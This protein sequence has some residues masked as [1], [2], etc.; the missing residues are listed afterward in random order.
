MKLTFLGATRTVTGSKY[1]IDVSGRKILIDCGLFQG[2]KAL[3]LRNWDSFPIDPNSIDCVLLTHAHI[4]HSGYIPLLVK[5]GFSGPILCTKAT[6]DLCE[7]LLPDSGHIQEEDAKRA[8]KYGYSK[9][10]PAK[11]LYTE[12]EARHALKR[13]QTV[14]FGAAYPLSEEISITFSHASHILG[15]SSIRLSYKG[16]SVLFSGDIGRLNDPL[17]NPPDKISEAEYVILESTYGDRLHEKSDPLV[18]IADIVQTTA[19]KGGSVLIPAFAVGRAQT[20]LYYLYQL[21]KSRAISPD[22][23]IFVD[24]PMATNATHLICK[25]TEELRIPVSE[26]RQICDRATYIQTPEESK[27]LANLSMPSIIISASGMATGGRVL[28]H[29]K[30]FLPNFRHTVLFAGFQAGGTRGARLVNGEKE[31][32]IH[33]QLIPVKARIENLRSLSAHADYE[34][35]LKWVGTLKHAPQTVFLTHGESEASESFKSKISNQL[36]WNVIIPDYLDMFE[37][38]TEKRYP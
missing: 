13:F 29:L 3:R 18:A 37:I 20:L 12:F 34:D 15:A 26:C 36:K 31:I 38:S 10:H 22:I 2:Y 11:P 6:R 27:R 32:K 25:Y 4:D 1:L 8:N 16:T 24:S 33:G 19:S 7:I 35:L 14:D 28:H 5:N 30:N 17:L 23:P 9:H 21:Q